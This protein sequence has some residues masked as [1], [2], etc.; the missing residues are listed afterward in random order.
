MSTEQISLGTALTIALAVACQLFAV[1]LRVPGI[2]LLLPVGFAAGALTELVRPE[3]LYG[4]AFPALVELA[5]AVILYEAGLLL[6]LERLDSH[7]R[8]VV[9]RLILV[10]VPLTWAVASF[11]SQWL[12]GLSPQAAATLGAILVVSGPTVVGP[13]L[14]AA[15]PGGRLHRVLS[16]EGV[17]ID[18]IGAIL[19][20]LVVHAIVASQPESL[21]SSAVQFAG[22]FGSGMVGGLVGAALLW[23]VLVK[24]GVGE[25]LGAS[26]QLGVVLLVA[27][28]CDAVR[29]DAGLVAAIVMGLVVAN[30]KAFALPVRRP[31]LETLVQLILGVL[32]ISISASVSPASLRDVLVPALGLVLLLVLL[33]RPVLTALATARS[34]LSRHERVFVGW[35]APRGIVAAATASTFGAS[36]AEVGVEG[37]QHILPVTFLVVVA[38]VTVYGLT[39]VPAAR[40]LGV[41]RSGETRPLVVGDQPWVVDLATALRECGLSVLMWSG[42]E[43][44]QERIR[45]AGLDLAP[46]GLLAA[47]T[48]QGAELEGVSMI[49]LLGDEDDFNALASALLAG[50]LD[51]GVYRVRPASGRGAVAPYLGGNQLFSPALSRDALSDRNRAGARFVSRPAAEEIE[52]DE[53]LLFVVRRN[54]LLVPVTEEATPAPEPGD[55]VVVLTS[56]SDRDR[57]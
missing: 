33:G 22:S 21:T 13:L 43:A 24:A 55:L 52:A 50:V 17:V 37:A 45:E 18:P 11:G 19:G 23:V 10:G 5:V 14:T 41:T 36:L 49:L 27:A 40:R 53:V 26:A 2:I 42:D 6:D 28:I 30:H 34:P 25:V 7:T 51:D 20:A 16:W 46:G 32:F 39:A 56:A 1:R 9:L 8:S 38:T 48:H 47:A 29:D 3:N 54:R 12:I 15:R 31:F 35:L 4:D 44:Q 57:A